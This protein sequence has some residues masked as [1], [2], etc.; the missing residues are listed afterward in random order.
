[1][2]MDDSFNYSDQPLVLVVDDVPDNLE[3][4]SELLLDS[5]RVKVASTGIN[6]LRIAASDTPP[7]LILLDVMMP[8]MDGYEVCRALKQ[9]PRTE[10]IPVIFLT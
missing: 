2:M 7:D 3:L 1:R 6:A 8:G 9:N 5:Y 4:M 10:N